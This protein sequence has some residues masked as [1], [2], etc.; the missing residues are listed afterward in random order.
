[1]GPKILNAPDPN[2]P[3]VNGAAPVNTVNMIK[4]EPSGASY[5][6]TTPGVYNGEPIASWY[7][8]VIPNPTPAGNGKRQ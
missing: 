7:P 2:Y 5:T 8:A 6:S 1:M 4:A 3:P